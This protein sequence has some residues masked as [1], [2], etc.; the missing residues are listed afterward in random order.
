MAQ[1]KTANATGYRSPATKRTGYTWAD[2][3]LD[4]KLLQRE[5]ERLQTAKKKVRT[6]TDKLVFDTELS[7]ALCSLELV[8]WRHQQLKDKK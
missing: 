1:Y 6:A 8:K 3:D 5:Y 7:A 4:V 2:L